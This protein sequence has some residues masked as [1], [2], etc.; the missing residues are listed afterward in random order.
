M[1]RQ[2]S[3]SPGKAIN[4]QGK[5]QTDSLFQTKD[6]MK[7]DKAVIHVLL[8]VTLLITKSVSRHLNTLKLYFDFM[9]FYYEVYLLH[10]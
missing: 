10:F 3:L 9:L 7:S 1:T 8:I 6:I 5:N 4:K 2:I